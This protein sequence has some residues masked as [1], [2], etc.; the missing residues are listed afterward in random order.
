MGE[1]RR[2][3]G[4]PA[5]RWEESRNG[6]VSEGKADYKRRRWPSSPARRTGRPGW[7]IR[8]CGTDF[9]DGLVVGRAT[10]EV[11]EKRTS[12]KMIRNEIVTRVAGVLTVVAGKRGGVIGVIGGRT[13][14]LSAHRLCGR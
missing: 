14:F 10:N 12:L 5:R 7:G 9:P 2:E 3:T 8:A 11:R 1:W 6:S 4:I 13:E